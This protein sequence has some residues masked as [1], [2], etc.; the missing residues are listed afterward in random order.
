[1]IPPRVIHTLDT[2][3]ELETLHSGH[4]R[5]VHDWAY[6][7]PDF[8]VVPRVTEG[9][10]LHLVVQVVK[11]CLQCGRPGSN[12]GSG[13]SFGEGNG[14]PVQCSSLEN[15]MDRGAWWATG[16]SV[17]KSRTRLSDQYTHTHTVTETNDFCHNYKSAS[18]KM[19]HERNS[20]LLLPPIT[21]RWIDI[22]CLVELNLH[23]EDTHT[24]TH[25]QVCG[26]THCDVCERKM[27]WFQKEL[28]ALCFLKGNS[29]EAHIKV[30]VQ[31]KHSI[32]TRYWR[33]LQKHDF[34]LNS[35]K[36]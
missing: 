18:G 3:L 11:I 2:I 33:I 13:R 35:E 17:T 5:P 24:H 29:E 21:P 25:K 31:R 32:L 23:N 8:W 20:S 10:W 26:T 16:L 36:T 19:L 27:L 14:N 4:L 7:I 1:M 6:L 12:P 28:W 22:N 34:L 30:P 9:L 15:S